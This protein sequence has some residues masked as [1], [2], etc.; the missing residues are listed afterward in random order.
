[1]DQHQA[2][3]S[4]PQ[5]S[6]ALC[7]YEP[8]STKVMPQAQRHDTWHVPPSN[9]W[10]SIKLPQLHP[11]CPWCYANVNHVTL[12]PC[13]RHK[14]NTHGMFHCPP[15]ATPQVSMV[16][17]KPTPCT[18]VAMP[19]AQRQHT[20]HVPLPSHGYTTTVHDVIQAYT[21]Y[22]HGHETDMRG[23]HMAHYRSIHGPVLERS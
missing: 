6:M 3:T 8:C 5:V 9:T 22:H 14:V 15:M 1:M 17:Y 18:T 11:E 23:P 2:P 12:W 16:L 21:M 13:P 4:T 19:Q 10:T 7:K 20:R